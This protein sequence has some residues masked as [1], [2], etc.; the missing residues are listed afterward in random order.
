MQHTRKTLFFKFKMSFKKNFVSNFSNKTMSILHMIFI[1]FLRLCL[2]TNNWR[3]SRNKLGQATAKYIK[4]ILFFYLFLP[5]RNKKKIRN[6]EH[7]KK[8]H[9]IYKK[10]TLLWQGA[11]Q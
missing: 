11:K 4:I 1:I 3:K 7:K 5:E 2:I 8:K 9:F 10:R 6:E